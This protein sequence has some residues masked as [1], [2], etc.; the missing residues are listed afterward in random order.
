MKN[1]KKIIAGLTIAIAAFGF[2]GCG[3]KATAKEEDKVIKLGVTGS[4]SEVWNYVKGELAKEG[5]TLEVVSFSDYTKPN[6][7]LAD[8]EID[9]NAFQHY[10]FFNKFIEEHKLDLTAIGETVIAPLGIYSDKIKDISELKDGD[11]ISIPNDATNEGRALILLQTA[12]L[13]K[14]APEAGILSTLKDVTENRLNLKLIEVDASTTA[15]TLE[16]VTASLINSG[17]AVDAGFNPANDSIFL[18]PI[19]E[20]SKPY[21]NIIAARTEDKDSEV[22]KRIVE[23]YQTEPVK[24]IINEL[25]KGSQQIS[26]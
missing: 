25:Y 2:T 10:A 16:D 20:N 24:E 13:I 22:L 15:R 1:T 19:D 21:V 8:G 7:A 4:E 14:I 23:I 26:W 12:G 11:E 18:E 6:Q 9:V 3:A 5:I 17:F